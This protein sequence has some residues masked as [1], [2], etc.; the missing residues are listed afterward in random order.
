MGPTCGP[1]A[2]MGL[3]P[4]RWGPGG[5]SPQHLFRDTLRPQLLEVLN[6]SDHSDLIR[7]YLD[8]GEIDRAIEAVQ[9]ERRPA[10]P[11]GSP[12][13]YG[14]GMRL[15]V[16]KAAEMTR[17]RAALEIDRR[18][19]EGLIDV[20]GRENYKEGVPPPQEGQG[21][22]RE[23]RRAEGVGLLRRRLARAEPQPAGVP[24]GADGRRAVTAGGRPRAARMPA[25][26]RVIHWR[27][28]ALRR[29]A[30]TLGV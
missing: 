13:S 12:F 18:Y 1:W 2:G 15:E 23:A 8:E 25:G 28:V 14:S 16:A 29:T 24:G 17:P 27:T 3:P 6:K 7:V 20:R 5:A 4:A 22:V 9:S 30:G 19:A 21:P 26:A 10:S 11:Y